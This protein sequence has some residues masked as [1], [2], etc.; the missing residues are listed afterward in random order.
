MNQFGENADDVI[1]VLR[2]YAI[3][4]S[5]GIQLPSR[6]YLDE[7]RAI[8]DITLGRAR[9]IAEEYKKKI[10]RSVNVNIR[11]SDGLY[12]GMYNATLDIGRVIDLLPIKERIIGMGFTS[13]KVGA[14]TIKAVR[15]TLRYGRFKKAFEY[16]K[17]YGGRNLSNVPTSKVSSLELIIK[18]KKGTKIQ[19]ASISIFN[20]GRVRLSSGYIDGAASEPTSLLQYV[21]SL[22]GLTMASKPVKINNITGEIKLG[23]TI[24]LDQLYALL[25]V[26][27]GAAKFDDMVLQATFEPAR[28]VFLTKAKKDSPFLYVKFG[29]RFTILMA[30][31]GTI[32]VEG[33]EA[34]QK[35]SAT[36][37]RFVEFIKTVGI[38]T[39]TAGGV[40]PDPKPSKLARRADNMPAPDITRRGTTCPIGKRPTPYSFQGTC[41]Q[42][43]GYYVRPN[44]QGQPCCYRIPQRPEY[45]RNKVASR[46]ARANVKVPES[47]R[48]IFGIGLNTNA[49]A[50]NVSKN[51]PTNIAFTQNKK[52]GFKI[53]SRQCSR[54]TKVALVDLAMRL[55]MSIPS[56]IS[57]PVLCAAIS[58]FVKK[59]KKTVAPMYMIDG[60]ASNTYKKSTL[61]KYAKTLGV[62]K[63]NGTKEELGKEIKRAANKMMNTPVNDANFDY[64]MNLARTL[65]NK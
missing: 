59:N 6:V 2:S 47:V 29:D 25:N 33:A 64:F 19:G 55:G 16:T 22:T 57:K 58:D 41:P 35:T 28:N 18:I 1:P 26:T 45:L 12:L 31:N 42:G 37:K 43:D 46:Y 7:L 34:P 60:K 24:D 21:D 49:K 9:E 15:M 63:V 62:T 56:V 13:K 30:K 48:K 3:A 65:K 8:L 40:R 14:Y 32:I 10:Y 61:V 36:V 11:Q 23:A 17:E 53:G 38:L 20:T 52:V 50:N 51:T 44:P 54:Y 27:K 5:G 39:P 4:T